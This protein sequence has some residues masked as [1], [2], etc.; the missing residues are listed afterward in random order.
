M[1]ETSINA[2]KA[3]LQISLEQNRS[4]IERAHLLS[5][6]NG[7]IKCLNGFTQKLRGLK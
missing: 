1:S 6:T 2:T 3:L 4:A 5:V 7:A